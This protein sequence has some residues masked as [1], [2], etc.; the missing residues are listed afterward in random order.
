[1]TIDD[2]AKRARVSGSTVYALF[3]SKEGILG[4]LIETA[5]FGE[6]YQAANAR[7]DGV[8][9]PVRQIALTPA[10]ARAIYESESAELGLIRGASAFSPTLRKLEQV[11]E[12][13]RFALQR[14][15]VERLYAEGRAKKNLPLE[16]A[17]RL[18]WMY[19]GRDI[20]R[21]LVQEGGWTP[22]EYETWLSETLIDALVEA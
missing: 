13:K 1:M 7:L 15:R 5:L 22:D 9:D 2:I 18:L 19:T 14:S 4:A 11:F 17:R 21:L 3:K 10:V 12:E 16:K 6:R 20:F 8:T